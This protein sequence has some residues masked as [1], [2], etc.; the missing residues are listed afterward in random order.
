MAGT[1]SGLQVFIL[2]LNIIF[3]VALTEEVPINFFLGVRIYVV[4]DFPLFS[5]VSAQHTP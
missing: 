4:S 5:V 2:F 3:L 1:T